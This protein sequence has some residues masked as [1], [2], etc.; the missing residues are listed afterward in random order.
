M[1]AGAVR[2]EHYMCG[3]KYVGGGS[4]CV[5]GGESCV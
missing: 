5:A 3:W 4:M 1:A 2:G